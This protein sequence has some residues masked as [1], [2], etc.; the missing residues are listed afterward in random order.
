MWPDAV[1]DLYAG[2]C[3]FVRTPAGITAPVCIGRGVLQGDA[4]SPILFDCF[5]GPLARCLQ[6]G[7]RGYTDGCLEATKA[8]PKMQMK[9]LTP[10]SSYADDSSLFCNTIA[11]L[12]LQAEKIN[13]HASWGAL[14]IPPINCAVM[15]MPHADIA[16]GAVK[17]PSLM[18]WE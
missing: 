5:M 13:K 17:F 18:G 7:G 3:T 8:T 10:C 11:D 1:R 14:K 6:A 12:C 4:L 15:G 2:A 9:C 16:S